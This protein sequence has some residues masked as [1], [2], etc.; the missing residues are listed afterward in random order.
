M[1]NPVRQKSGAGIIL[2]RLGDVAL[3]D[4]LEIPILPRA[5]V[6]LFQAFLEFGKDFIEA[7]R[8]EGLHRVVS[9]V[10]VCGDPGL[11]TGGRE[12]LCKE[13]GLVAKLFV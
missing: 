6:N 5:V 10:K 7:P 4:L 9:V 1:V 13:T 11:R 8:F 12:K 3:F 2:R